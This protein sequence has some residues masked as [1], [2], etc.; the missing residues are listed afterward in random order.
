MRFGEVL[1]LYMDE[2]DIDV[3]ELSERIGCQRS[4]IYALL[5]GYAKDPTLRRAKEIADALGISLQELSD[6][7]DEQ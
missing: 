2:L 7:M 3:K 6:R 5:S 1:Q 4:A